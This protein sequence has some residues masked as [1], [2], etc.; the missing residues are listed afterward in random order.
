MV[1]D[2]ASSATTAVATTATDPG[3]I[4]ARVE[5]KALART[6]DLAVLRWLVPLALLHGLL[7][8][9]LFPPWQHYDETAH[10]LYA[11]EIAAGEL[12]VPGPASALLRREIADSMYRFRFFPPD[13][14]PDLLG[15]EPPVVGID[16]RVHPPL[17]YALVA[18][19]LRL[20]QSTAIEQQ[21]FVARGVSLILYV[22]TV[23]TAWRIGVVLAPDDPPMQRLV[24]LLVLLA[25]AFAD[26]MVAVNNDVLLN[27][28]LTITFLGAVLLV[29][30]GLQPLPIAL[31]LLGIVVA[32]LTKRTALV[33]FVPLTFAVVWAVLRR[34]L[35]WWVMLLIGAFAVAVLGFATLQ[36]SVVESPSG[37]H[38]ILG[39]RPWVANFDRIYLR[40]DIDATVRSFTDLDRIGDRYWT[41]VVVAFG[42]YYTHF[43][44]GQVTLP[45]IWIWIV[46][47][48]S[49]VATFGLI[50]GGADERRRLTL[51]QRRC[52][53]LFLIAVV[54]S[55]L[56]LFVRLHPLPSIEVSTYIPRARYMFWAMVPNL[57]LLSLG[58]IWA[59]PAHWRRYTP[60]VLLGFFTCLDLGTWL[61]TIVQYYYR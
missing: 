46:S 54:V 34:P 3:A 8:L 21:L 48:L 38:T 4:G 25:P 27:L 41:L 42:G 13:V 9:A 6:C 29:R 53:W 22:L 20:L 19:P 23:L 52:L 60:L 49:L 50:V 30:D 58:L 5:R 31:V 44:W 24:P 57:W 10:F 15:P 14:Q 36:P 56:S 1:Q 33:A 40:M 7:Y 37:T 47:G 2:H 43:G 12:A 28:S 61:W 18:L 55:W 16:Q 45:T 35:S 17:Y 59:T 51:W 39:V 11:A 26:I 32:L